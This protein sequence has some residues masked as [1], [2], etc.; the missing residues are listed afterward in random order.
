MGYISKT[1]TGKKNLGQAITEGLEKGFDIYSKITDFQQK[2]QEFAWKAQE[3]KI[4]LND[5]QE[6]QRQMSVASGWRQIS[7]LHKLNMLDNPDGIAKAS[8]YFRAGGLPIAPEQLSGLSKEARAAFGGTSSQISAELEIIKAYAFRDPKNFS[9]ETDIPKLQASRQR[10]QQL[11]SSVKNLEGVI[12]GISDSL[13][14]TLA[15]YD[16]NY[17]KIISRIQGQQ[18]YERE[19]SGKKEIENIKGDWNVKE[20]LAG[21]TGD[22]SGDTST[23]EAEEQKSLAKAINKGVPASR[24]TIKVLDKLDK[25]LPK[26]SVG[27]F[28]GS[29]IG[30]EA[31]KAINSDAQEFDQLIKSGQIEKFM[32]FAG[33]AGVRSMD[34]PEEQKRIM[35]TLLTTDRNE[36]AFKAIMKT[37]REGALEYQ[38]RI[39][40]K[41]AWKASGKRMIDF[42]SKYD[43]Q[44]INVGETIDLSPKVQDLAGKYWK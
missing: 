37:I 18:E 5:L 10:V 6:Q 27:Y 3:A 24:D 39:R 23:F 20:K 17:E 31:Q 21:K 7:D 19:L 41:Q 40:E 30:W 8:E 43:Q 2:Q 4:K 26:V 22:G 42:V 32:Q 29:K 13:K 11:R 38:D 33:E 25:L 28:K 35:D 1:T 12:P 16:A 14:Q 15:D 44:N 34:T 9:A 36:K